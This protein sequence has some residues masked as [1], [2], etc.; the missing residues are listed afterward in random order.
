M[1]LAIGMT[2][3]PRKDITLVT[4]IGMM[5]QAFVGDELHVFAEPG[6]KLDFL[7]GV[8]I[9][10]NWT[11]LGVCGNWVHALTWLLHHTAAEHV[12]VCENDVAWCEGA[13]RVL[14][15][16]LQ[17]VGDYGFCSLYTRQPHQA[18]TQQPQ[19]GWLRR[20]GTSRWNGAQALCLHRP[21]AE[22]FCR[23]ERLL[24]VIRDPDALDGAG[25]VDSVLG[26]FFAAYCQPS[27]YHVP[28]LTDHV[29]GTS[30]RVGHTVDPTHRGLQYT[31]DFGA[32]TFN[33]T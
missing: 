16:Q 21:A 17:A 1:Q 19:Y 2:A 13:R 9:H 4:S 8:H 30:A 18:T 3:A 22:E 28:S 7:F 33:H 14:T 29:G 23:D 26:D 11:R 10:C 6:T 24:A 25:G 32:E 12:L 31:A 20:E 15:S 5:R 27:W